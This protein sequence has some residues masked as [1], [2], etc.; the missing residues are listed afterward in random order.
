MQAVRV[1]VL[2]HGEEH[3]DAARLLRELHEPVEQRLRLLQLTLLLLRQRRGRQAGLRRRREGE[4]ALVND[5]AE[6]HIVVVHN[7]YHLV[8]ERHVG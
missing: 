5:E 3:V 8:K 4:V 1:S 2:G 7:F 6:V